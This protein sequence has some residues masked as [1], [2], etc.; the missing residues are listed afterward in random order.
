MYQDSGYG[1]DTFPMITEMID[2]KLDDL[3]RDQ[4]SFI[5]ICFD[6]YAE[7]DEY[8]LEVIDEELKSWTEKEFIG[9]LEAYQNM[10]TEQLVLKYQ[11]IIELAYK[12]LLPR[13]KKIESQ[14]YYHIIGCEFKA[15]ICNI[16]PDSKLEKEI[17]E[18]TE[19][20]EV[21]NEISQQISNSHPTKLKFVYIYSNFLYEIIEDIRMAKRVVKDTLKTAQ[22]DL[23]DFNIKDKQRSIAYIEK[24]EDNL[25]KFRSKKK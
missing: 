13:A 18:A 24:L 21:A 20:H 1:K 7:A 4:K 19:L 15:R 22:D 25:V 23:D 3:T 12:K 2:L 9:E 5:K 14:L 8:S 10:I 16:V 11:E 6:K 17:K